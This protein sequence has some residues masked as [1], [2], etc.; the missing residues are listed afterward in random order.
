M[1]WREQFQEAFKDNLPELME[2]CF[3]SADASSYGIFDNFYLKFAIA[4]KGRNFQEAKNNLLKINHISIENKVEQSCHKNYSLLL[5]LLLENMQGTY[6]EPSNII[7]L[8]QKNRDFNH[9]TLWG[10]A[11][12]GY[13]DLGFVFPLFS[14]LYI[15]NGSLSNFTKTAIS[16][17]SF[18]SLMI[19]KAESNDPFSYIRLNDGEG[20]L[21]YMLRRLPQTLSTMPFECYLAI[22]GLW[23]GWFDQDILDT[24][25]EFLHLLRDSYSEVLAKNSVVGIDIGVVENWR[26]SKGLESKIGCYFSNYE[27]YKSSK[28]NDFKLVNS[29]VLYDLQD[30]DNFLTDFLKQYQWNTISCHENLK[31]KLNHKAIRIKKE[32]VVPAEQRF[33]TLFELNSRAGHH[34]DFFDKVCQELQDINSKHSR[35]WLI[36]AGPLG[37]IYAT[38]LKN[39]GCYVLDIGAIMDGLA[40]FARRPRL[41]SFLMDT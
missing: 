35:Y 17:E 32:I 2:K 25:I 40:G 13:Y 11:N 1:N 15:N 21:L 5:L 26:D 14:Q 37:K 20:C 3:E 41:R 8:Y 24:P 36:A 31:D 22:Q 9:N 30:R 6:I 7:N 12:G 38:I 27:A 16:L 4:L 10:M 34:I 29:S 28:S 33:N 19:N 39:R 18:K 23:R